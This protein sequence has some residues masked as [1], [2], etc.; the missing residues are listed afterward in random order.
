MEAATIGSLPPIKV[1]HCVGRSFSRPRKRSQAHAPPYGV[2]Y[3]PRTQDDTAS[4]IELFDLVA[5]CTCI[6]QAYD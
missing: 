3:M 5:V 1:T 6:S 4:L 2:S